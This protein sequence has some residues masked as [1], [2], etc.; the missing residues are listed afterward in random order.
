MFYVDSNQK[1]TFELSFSF[2][3][4]LHETHLKDKPLGFNN[5]H[6]HGEQQFSLILEGPVIMTLLGEDYLLH[7][8]DAIFINSNVE[9]MT[10]PV[11]PGTGRY[12]SINYQPSLLALFRGSAIEQKYLLPYVK[13]PR[14]QAIPLLWK[15]ESDWS[16]LEQVQ[17]MFETLQTEPYGY[18]LDACGRLFHIWKLLLERNEAVS[19]PAQHIEHNEARAIL[20]YLHAHYPE[21]LTL[22]EIASKVH[23]SKSECCRL[24]RIAYGSSIISYLTDYRLQQSIAML[25]ETPLSVL[26]IS[27]RCGFNSTSYFI[28]IFREKVGQTPLQYRR[29]IKR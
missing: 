29:S 28:K 24:F 17:S 2:P 6:W 20:T 7:P 27:E 18:E 16:I 8:G 13:D 12:L 25:A 1:A 10:R 3:L 5:W 15:H 22:D 21:R 4:I 14:M 23:I 9:H 11:T 26:E 19:V